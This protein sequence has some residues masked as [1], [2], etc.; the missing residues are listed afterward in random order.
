VFAYSS[1][2]TDEII[3]K[4]NK[5]GFISCLPSPLTVGTVR[6]LISE[7]LD[8][9]VDAEIDSMFETLFPHN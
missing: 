7:Y 8:T 4:T 1:L 9:F 2:V 5:A 3:E 6:S